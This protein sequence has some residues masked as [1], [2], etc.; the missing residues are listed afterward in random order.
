[1]HAKG[2]EALEVAGIAHAA[3]GNETLAGCPVERLPYAVERRPAAGSDAI[4]RHHDHPLG[5]QPGRVEE[6]GGSQ[7]AVAAGVEGE[8]GLRRRG[9]DR[10][11]RFEG[12]DAFRPDHGRPPRA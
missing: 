5:P 7:P 10:G 1:M 9:T 6:G 11:E 4:E 2:L 3:G 12:S 8:D